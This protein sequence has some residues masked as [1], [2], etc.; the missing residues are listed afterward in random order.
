MD[1]SS[2][3]TGGSVES[4]VC[5]FNDED[6]LVSVFLKNKNS[7]TTGGSSTWNRKPM[8]PKGH[9]RSHIRSLKTVPR[10]SQKRA[11]SSTG[12]RTVFSWLLHSGVVALHEVIQLRRPEDDAMLKEAI[13]IR[14][15]LICLC[16]NEI[17]SIS[18]FET[19]AGMT[20]KWPGMN[21]VLESG[22]P[23]ALCQ[24]EA[25]SAEYK[26]RKVPLESSQI[27]EGD[28]L[29]GLCGLEGELVWCD[30]CP[31]TFHQ[32]CLFEQY[33]LRLI[34]MQNALT[35]VLDIGRSRISTWMRIQ[36]G[37]DVPLYA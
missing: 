34:N 24:L 33:L 18:E 11:W 21:L 23:L 32:A 29:C 28:D 19:H 22:K 7:V 35:S 36:S 9:S 12:P 14:D 2:G 26:A 30:N 3:S 6:L 27:A 15:G 20:P 4:E 25:W 31:A 1:A 13:L 8:N 16:C 17:F 37:L 10:H 5:Q